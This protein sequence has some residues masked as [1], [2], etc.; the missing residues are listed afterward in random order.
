M[1]LEVSHTLLAECES[2]G[3]N[4]SMP[5]CT[6]SASAGDDPV[7]PNAHARFARLGNVAG[8]AW[9]FELAVVDDWRKRDL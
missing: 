4:A 6:R 2:I 3:G 9:V 8:A 5:C 1:A 7:A